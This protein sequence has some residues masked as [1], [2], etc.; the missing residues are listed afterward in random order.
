MT[1]IQLQLTC[2]LVSEKIQL[3]NISMHIFK[4]ITYT[5]S[6]MNLVYELPLT[7]HQRSLAHHMESC[8][9]LTVALHLRLQ[10]PSSIALT[11]HT[12]DCTDHTADCTEHTLYINH[13]LPLLLGRVLFSILLVLATYQAFPFLC[14]FSCIDLRFSRRVLAALRSHS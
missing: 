1:F 7:H 11:T 14:S 12:A 8:T 6:V 10:F 4:Y 13:G 2:N 5:I 9:T 3:A